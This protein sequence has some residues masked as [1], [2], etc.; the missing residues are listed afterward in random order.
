MHEH[1][2][3]GRVYMYCIACPGYFHGVDLRVDLYIIMFIRDPYHHIE[4][5]LEVE[6]EMKLIYILQL[7][8]LLS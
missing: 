1:Y 6:I 5:N 7:Y 3:V 2:F 4:Q 8:L